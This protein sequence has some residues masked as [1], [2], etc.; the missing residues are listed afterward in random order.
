M[1]LTQYKDEEWGLVIDSS[2]RN[3]NWLS[4]TGV[5][6]TRPAVSF[7]FD[8][9][10]DPYLWSWILVN[11]LKNINSGAS[12]TDG[13]FAKSPRCDKGAYW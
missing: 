10:S 9:C 6:K 13:I 7:Q 2:K 4:D 1:G 8:L 5:S 11:G 3:L 12:T